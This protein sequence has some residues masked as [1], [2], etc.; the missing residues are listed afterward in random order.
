MAV[1]IE[2]GQPFYRLISF[3]VLS[4]LAWKPKLGGVD[5]VGQIRLF[6]YQVHHDDR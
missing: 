5:S 6:H 2:D 4:T 1:S 3:L